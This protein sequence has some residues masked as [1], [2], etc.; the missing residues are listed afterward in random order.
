MQDRSF[1]EPGEPMRL[2]HLQRSCSC[3][4]TVSLVVFRLD[5][6]VPLFLHDCFTPLAVLLPLLLH[7]PTC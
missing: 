1:V 4:K 7:L 3:V 6:L 5:N 2:C